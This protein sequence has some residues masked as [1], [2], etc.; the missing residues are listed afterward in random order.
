MIFSS[1]CNNSSSDTSSPSSSPKL[2]PV[3]ISSDMELMPAEG[4]SGKSF[5][6]GANWTYWNKGALFEW[7]NPGGDYLDAELVAQGNAAWSSQTV[8]DT[9]SIKELVFDVSVLVDNWLNKTLSNRGF[10]LKHQSGSGGPIDFAS[11]EHSEADYHPKLIITKLNS[12]IVELAPLGDTHLTASTKTVTFG[13]ESSMRVRDDMSLLVWFDLSS[14]EDASVLEARLVLTTTAQYTSSDSVIGVYAIKTDEWDRSAPVMGLANNY[15]NDEGIE[16]HSDVLLHYSFDTL[17][18]SDGA[19]FLDGS[20]DSNHA[21]NIW[22]CVDEYPTGRATD[23]STLVPAIGIPGLAAM[24]QGSALCSRLK[25]EAGPANQQGLGNYGMSL[26]KSVLDMTG[27]E[28]TDELYVRVY[29]YLGETWGENTLNESG[30]R[31]GGISGTYGATSYAGGWGGRRTNGTNGWSA[32]GGYV[33]QVP[34]GYNPLQGSTT[35]ATYLYHA[36]QPTGYGEQLKWGLTLNGSI[37]KGRWYSIEQY[38]KMNTTDGNNLQGSSGNHDGIVRGWVDG[39]LVFER[40]GIRFTDMDYI[41][42]QTAD[43]GLY[44]GGFGNTPHDQHIAID[45]IVVA[46]SY[47]GPKKVN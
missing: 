47:I 36:D 19:G 10:L 27:E 1:G 35:L 44:Y 43:F 34:Y 11:K 14:I 33:A 7:D 20:A 45:D 15:L 6:D 25:Y 30:K 16:S 9:D 28:H 26:K 37:K 18:E 13:Q 12:D 8:S 3:T 39:R 23:G 22:S 2:P 29:L 46:K 5:D 21:E 32:R 42:I 31:P 24:S 4:G 17:A 38:V 41:K 40:K